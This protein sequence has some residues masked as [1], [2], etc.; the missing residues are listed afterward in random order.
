MLNQQGDVIAIVD[1]SGNVA[2]QYRYNAWGS[3]INYTKTGTSGDKLYQYNALKYRGYYYDTDLGLYYLESRYYDPEICRLVNA[4]DIEVLSVEQGNMLQDNLYAYCLNNPVKHIDED[5][6]FAISTFLGAMAGGAIGGTIVSTISYVVTSSLNGEDVTLKGV[7]NAAL[8]GFAT[9]AIG[10]AIGMISA[11]SLL[12]ENGLKL[13]SS[14]AVGVGMAI[15]SGSENKNWRYGIRTGLYTFMATMGGGS[16]IPGT[17]AG[18]WNTA[19]A[20]YAIS[21]SVGTV[22]EVISIAD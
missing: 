6:N 18:F 14:L 21:L 3:Q 10:G 22:M 19:F 1:S 17:G 11:N 13:V 20:N 9:G 2:V 15:K 5:G 7:W 12:L 16:M 4:D 8:T